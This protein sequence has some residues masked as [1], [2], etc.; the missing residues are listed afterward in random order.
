M[1]PTPPPVKN[2]RSNSGLK[3]IDNNIIFVLI[4]FPKIATNASKK[5]GEVF[6]IKELRSRAPASLG[7]VLHTIYYIYIQIFIK[8]SRTFI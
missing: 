5:F 6:A 1:P 3:I 4:F 7:P 2:P 8:Q